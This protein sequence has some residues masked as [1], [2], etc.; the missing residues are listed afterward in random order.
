V[1][2]SPLTFEL[3][4][5][6]EGKSTRRVP[7]G[8][9]SLKLDDDST[10]LN[11]SVQIEFFRSDHF[12]RVFFEVEAETRLVCDRSLKPFKES[13]SGEYEVIFYPE[14]HEEHE[15]EKGKVKEIDADRLTISIDDEVRDTIMLQI[16]VRKLHPD[17]LDD[18]GKPKEFGTKVFGKNVEDESDEGQPIDPRWEELK[19]L[20]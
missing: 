16:P 3:Q 13:V 14:S 17:L 12:I 7:L 6:P 18:E 20:K 15:T 8:E 2:T 9:N 19:K 1:K 11:A 5:I 10:L 4:E